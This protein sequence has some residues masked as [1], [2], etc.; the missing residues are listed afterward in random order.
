MSRVLAWKVTATFLVF[1]IPIM[2]ATMIITLNLIATHQTVEYLNTVALRETQIDSSFHVNYQRLLA[3][4][5]TFALYGE[6]DEA[7]EARVLIE[8]LEQALQQG[9]AIHESYAELS[10][11]WQGR[12]DTERHEA[13]EA[14][15]K[16][17]FEELVAIAQNVFTSE[18]QRTPAELDVLIEKLEELEATDSAVRAETVR[19]AQAEGDTVL[20]ILNGQ[21]RAVI[22]TFGVMLGSLLA[23]MGLALWWAQRT[24]IRPI[25]RLAQVA[26]AVIDGRLDQQVA[27]TSEDELGTLQRSFN[28]MVAGLRTQ[29]NALEQQNTALLTKQ[30]AL[31][32]ALHELEQSAQ[33][34]TTLQQQVIQAQQDAL[35]ELSSPLIP[36]AD[37]VVVMP[38][39]GSIDASRAEQILKSLLSG[40][41]QHRANVAIIDITGVQMVDTSVAQ[42]LLQATQAITLLGAQTMLTGVKPQVAQTFVHLG[43]DLSNIQ[44]FSTLQQGIAA[45]VTPHVR[46][47]APARG[48][49]R[50][51]GGLGKLALS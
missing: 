50:S 17:E 10:P 28:A 33:E 13:L 44:T 31:A 26:G 25:N 1:L 15:R 34:R 41:E 4:V 9:D 29:H 11:A 51:T 21:L 12:I 36:I 38:L 40:V 43:I 8:A 5:A 16:A 23:L 6:A 39:I 7:D 24:I 20:S 35:R 3:E 48:K 18:Q 47:E 46:P 30:D 45:T 22:L 14:R 27:I 42:V 2:I 32:Q 49:P 37:K 19:L